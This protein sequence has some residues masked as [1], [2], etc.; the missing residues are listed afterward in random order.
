MPPVVCMPV[1]IFMRGP[2]L[3][4]DTGASMRIETC[5]A[6]AYACVDRCRDL[7]MGICT[8]MRTHGYTHV[9]AYPFVGTHVS[10]HVL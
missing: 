2:V 4:S 6:S 3:C 5:T 7:C 1:D 8:N 10:R 9:C